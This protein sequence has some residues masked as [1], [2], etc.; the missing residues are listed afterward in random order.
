MFAKAGGIVPMQSDPLSDMTVN[1]RALDVVIFP[2]AD[3]SFAMREDSGEFREVCADAAAAQES[4]TAVTAMTWQWDD[5][6]SPQFVIEAPTGNT[7][8]VPERRDWTLIFRGVAR[9]A[10]QVIVGGEAWNKDLVGTTVVDYD[11]ETMSLSVKLY[12]VPSSSRIQVLFPQGLALA[13]SPTEADCER[14]LFD[15]QMLYTT[16]EHA[17]AQISRY[18]VAAIPGL[19][20]LEREQ[21]N[22][23]DFFQSH[24]PESVIGALE[25]VLLRG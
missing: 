11:A 12:D 14:I 13:E 17:M 19:R 6:R 18:G 21:R 4:A 24:M 10:M 25:E 1:P 15:A 5:G 2:G 22:E 20:T 16:K 3:G 8:V 7:S 9:S 23:R